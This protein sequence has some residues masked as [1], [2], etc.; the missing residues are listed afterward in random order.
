MAIFYLIIAA[1]LLPWLLILAGAVRRWRRVGGRLLRLQVEGAALIL[2]AL[3]A[4]WV[5]FDP[6]FGFADDPA[7]GWPY[8][9][10]RGEV[11]LFSIGLLLLLMGHF[12]S[13]RPRPGLKPW[14]VS[15][16][17]ASVVGIAI[18]SVV[19]V[20]LLLRGEAPL[21]NTLPWSMARAAFM[22]G[23]YPY[24]LAYFTMSTNAPEPPEDSF[25]DAAEGEE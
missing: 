1:L 6:N 22:L 10:S 19:G 25:S 8:W 2:V 12:L 20:L 21:F 4:N 9:F 13:R 5:V 23:F 16:S 18:G 15:A 7:E 14:P 17:I 24:A 3:V 11:G